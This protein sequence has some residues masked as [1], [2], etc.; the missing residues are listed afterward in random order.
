MFDAA[1]TDRALSELLTIKPGGYIAAIG[2]K[3]RLHRLAA[4]IEDFGLQIRG[5]VFWLNR[6]SYDPVVLA[7]NPGPK[8][9]PLGIDDC[10]QAPEDGRLY[11]KTTNKIVTT[12]GDPNGRWPNDFL[13]THIETCTSSRYENDDCA[14]GCPVNDIA[15]QGGGMKSGDSMK[16]GSIMR[17]GYSGGLGMNLNGFSSPGGTAARFF[18]QANSKA[19]LI[20]WVIRLINPNGGVLLDLRT[21]P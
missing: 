6:G 16:P 14:D 1:I 20:E 15:A 5:T 18:C 9:L 3:E 12:T 21:A 19:E 2:A 17:E 10:R 11:E 4:D 7:R 8:M 13:I